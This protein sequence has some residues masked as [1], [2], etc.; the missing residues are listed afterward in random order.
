M[1]KTPILDV[2]GLRCPL[3]VL[4]TRKML[5]K[6]APGDRLEVV[7]TDPVS[8]VDLPHFC[9]TEGHE[10]LDQQQVGATFRFL[11]RKKQA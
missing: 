6:L 11:I 1:K 9:R 5:A 8:V 10:L 3:P 4:K 7:T 2:T